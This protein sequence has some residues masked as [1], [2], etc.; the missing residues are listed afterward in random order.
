MENLTPTEV[1]KNY[2]V[3]EIVESNDHQHLEGAW[4]IEES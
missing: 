2:K 4:H 1:A 3:E